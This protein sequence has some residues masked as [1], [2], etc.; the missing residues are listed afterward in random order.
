MLFFGRKT[1]TFIFL[2][3]KNMACFLVPTAEAVVT[4][5]IK[6]AVKAKE[7]KS[8]L[9]LSEISA[10]EKIEKNVKIPFSRKLSWLNN[11]LWGGAL[12]LAFEHLWHGEIQPWFPFLTAASNP[13][14]TAVMLHEMATVGVAMAL[15]VTAVWCVMLIAV[16][17]TERKALKTRKTV[18]E[19]TP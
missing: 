18:T 12:L 9:K 11:M 17:I 14:D 16:N 15:S 4:T 5:V 13:A 8:Q 3:R 1:H 19:A 6:K 7:E 2:R 10:E